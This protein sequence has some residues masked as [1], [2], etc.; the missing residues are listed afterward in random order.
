[1]CNSC[2]GIARGEDIDVIEI[3]AASNTGVDNVRDLISNTAE[4]VIG[5]Q[6][7]DAIA[8]RTLRRVKALAEAPA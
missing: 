5:P 2:Q 3:D 6:F 4:R 8:G 1:M 7:I